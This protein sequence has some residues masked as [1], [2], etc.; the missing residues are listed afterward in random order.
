LDY[1]LTP[2]KPAAKAAANSFFG[3]LVDR[4]SGV[5]KGVCQLTWRLTHDVVGSMVKIQK[6]IVT[7]N[8]SITLQKGKPVKVAWP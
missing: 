3:P 8:Q 2:G 4:K 1:V 6:V 7:S 5:G